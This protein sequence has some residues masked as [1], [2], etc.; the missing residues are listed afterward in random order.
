METRGNGSGLYGGCSSRTDRLLRKRLGGRKPLKRKRL[1]SLVKR[2]T[3][4]T[5]MGRFTASMQVRRLPFR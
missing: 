4:W 5:W 3:I 2:W 1:K